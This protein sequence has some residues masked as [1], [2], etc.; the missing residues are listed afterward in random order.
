MPENL[1]RKNLNK[2]HMK[3]DKL[4]GNAAG[5]QLGKCMR[6]WQ[7]VDT[8]RILPYTNI[9]SYTL[10]S[11]TRGLRARNMLWSL[12]LLRDILKYSQIK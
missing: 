10:T 5:A 4:Q 8:T 9:T 7:L 1:Y 2:H 12:L 11:L 3:R 6:R